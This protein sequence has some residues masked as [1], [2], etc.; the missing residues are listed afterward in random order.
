MEA[1]DGEIGKVEEFYFD[2]DGWVI[3]YLVLQT[4]KWLSGR[5]VL[6]SPAAVLK[7]PWKAGSL[8]VD[9]TKEQIERSPDIDTNRPVFRQQEMML[10]G[11]YGWPGYWKS[12]FYGEG[13]A[14]DDNN[15]DLHLRSS[16]QVT[17]YHVHGT[18]GEVGKLTDFIMDDQTWKITHLVVG[19]SGQADGSHVLV[20]VE[21]IKQMS[22]KDADIYCDM[23][24]AVVDDMVNI[25]NV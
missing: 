8:F 22:W 15:V 21:H 14:G 17:G 11:H 24:A 23:A 16:I 13:V 20:P 9:L 10:Y 19:L 1:K 7:G 4:E 3:R 2:D 12:G 6:I 18:D 5:K 25:P